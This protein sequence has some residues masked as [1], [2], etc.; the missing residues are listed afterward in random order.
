MDNCDLMAE[1][2][3]QISKILKNK[4]ASPEKENQFCNAKNLQT[5]LEQLSQV[6][7]LFNKKLQE[8]LNR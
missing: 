1:V 6:C 7:L 3:A 5:C 4:F 8:L 2:D